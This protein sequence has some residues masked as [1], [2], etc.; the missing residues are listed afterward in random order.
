MTTSLLGVGLYTIPEAA[1][2]LGA[3]KIDV[4]RWMFGYDYNVRGEKRHQDP[5]AGEQLAVDG[6]KALTFHDLLEFRFVNALRG[7]GVSLQAIRKA[8][9]N[10]R[11][12]FDAKHPFVLKRIETDGLTIFA[13]AADDTDDEKLLDLVRK[14]YGFRRFLENAFIKGIEFDDDVAS[15]WYP[16]ENSKSIVLDPER[17]F[18]RPIMS[19]FG[20]PTWVL[21]EA[22][23]AE[24]KDRGR[25]ARIYGVTPRAVDQAVQFESARLH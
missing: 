1:R 4:H 13:N 5:V 9:T 3:K 17:S 6:A 11:E 14:Q 25:I 20:I 16:V 7:C 2:L 12:L 21:Y 24:N 10:A 19:R 18:G 8:A 22:Y 15:R 23:L